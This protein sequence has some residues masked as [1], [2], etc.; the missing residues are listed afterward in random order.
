M[1][2]KI[3]DFGG[4]PGKGFLC[5]S[6]G[7]HDLKKLDYIIIEI[8][9][10]CAIGK[11]IF[12]NNNDVKFLTKF[13][14]LQKTDIFHF[15][16]CLQYIEDW[17]KVVKEAITYSPQYLVF[18]DLFAG[19]IEPFVTTQIMYDQKMPFHFLN[20]NNFIKFIENNGYDLRFCSNYHV[21]IQGHYGF[22]PTQD[23]PIEKQLK[24]SSNLLFIKNKNKKMK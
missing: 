23:F 8:P 21:C 24:H 6:K 4:G 10:I 19:N 9:E 20:I 15:G 1:Q 16:S 22:L 5:L 2:L 18:S 13:P 7:I 14:P 12:L 3:I 17:Q 11:K